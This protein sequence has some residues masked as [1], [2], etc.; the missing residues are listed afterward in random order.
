MNRQ[1]LHFLLV[2][3]SAAAV[4]FAVL[5][6]SVVWLGF[7]PAWANAFAFCCAFAVSFSGH[8][9]KTFKPAQ[10]SSKP[11]QHS[12]WQWLLTSLGGFAL[13]QS[14]FVLGLRLFGEAAYP[15]I[16]FGVTLLVTLFTF[17]LGKFW[18][19]KHPNPTS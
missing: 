11:W 8:R 5:Q 7:S 18:A 4:H 13:N 6:S 10:G 3:G 9:H 2:G 1:T 16:W 17:M 14:L 15:F 12:L 19:F